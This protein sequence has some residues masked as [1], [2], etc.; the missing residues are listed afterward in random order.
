[1]QSI[2]PQINELHAAFC[3]ASGRTI[4]L[5]PPIERWWQ[6]ALKYEITPAMVRMVMHARIKR[7]YSS[8]ELRFHCLSLKLLIGDEERLAQFVDEAAQ[9]EAM[10]RKRVFVPG[11]AEALKATGRAGEPEPAKAR[12]IN[13]V[14]EAMRR[15][16]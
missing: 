4:N 15:A 13:E 3:E 7:N 1:M 6:E 14:F 12:S 10:K 2:I 8:A 11:K 9:L 16:G 5:I